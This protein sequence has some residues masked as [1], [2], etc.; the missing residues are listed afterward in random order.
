MKFR[1]LLITFFRSHKIAGKP[2]NDPVSHLATAGNV[3]RD[4]I[5]LYCRQAERGIGRGEELLDPKVAGWLIYESE[6]MPGGLEGNPVRDYLERKL[7]DQEKTTE[8][9]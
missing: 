5:Y 2:V 1:A 9:R 8:R 3:S 6:K 7:A 4:T